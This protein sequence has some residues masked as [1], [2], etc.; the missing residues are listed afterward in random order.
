[1]IDP[2]C[3]NQ[4][5]T[6]ERGH[7][8]ALMGSIYTHATSVIVWLGRSDPELEKFHFLHMLLC[9]ALGGLIQREGLEKVCTVYSE[10]S[11]ILEQ[12]GFSADIAAPLSIPPP[13]LEHWKAYAK[14]Y[15]R[16]FFQRAWKNTLMLSAVRLRLIT[17]GMSR[18]FPI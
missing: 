17:F 14:F 11:T 7:Q 12:L 8:V 5:D 16:R 10:D 3:I 18:P 4:L 9:P 13:S 2:V 6:Q 15:E 1:M